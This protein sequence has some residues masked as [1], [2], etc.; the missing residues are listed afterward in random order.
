MRIELQTDFQVQQ[1]NISAVRLVFGMERDRFDADRLE[2]FRLFVAAQLPFTSLDENVVWSDT[3][4]G[5]IIIL[6]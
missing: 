4:G 3:F 5:D 6:L 1:S 2:G